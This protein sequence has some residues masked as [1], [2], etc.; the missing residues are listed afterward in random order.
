MVRPEAIGAMLPAF[1][2][3]YGNP[4]GA[5]R[6]AKEANHLLDDARDTV[7]TAMG[8]EAGQIVFTAGGTE[9]D[10]LAIRGVIDAVGGL[11]VCSAV[12]HHAVLDPVEYLEGRV[13]GVGTDGRLDLDQL[14][15]AVDDSV[16]I[17]SIMLANNETGIVQPLSEVVGIV[18][19]K[20]PDALVHTDAVQA[21]CWLDVAEAATGVDL[22]S[23]SA[24]KFGG[25]KGV[26]ALV[27]G[28]RARLHPLF[29][30]GGQERDRRGGT[31][32]VPGIAAMAAALDG[33]LNERPVA[34]TRVASLRDRLADGIRSAIDGVVESGVPGHDRTNKTANICH[35]CFEGVESE[36]LLFLLEKEGIMASAAS[37]CASGAMDP[38]HV[39]AA[40]GYSPQ[41]AGGS[42]RLS[43]GYSTTEADIDAVL[44]VVPAAVSQ[45]RAGS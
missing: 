10:N 18:R 41:L 6:M 29:L 28:D 4:S 21:V 44:D 15:A 22:I 25:P 20:A 45:L 43:L 32:N 39:L 40:M 31:H 1:T 17:V 38:S 11:P 5:H 27:V 33:V 26:G 30:G 42:L 7:A 3:L 23:I 36:A 12:E 16:S 24:H 34:R 35:L 13:V 2:E 19:R 8:A 9:A 14:A 37:S